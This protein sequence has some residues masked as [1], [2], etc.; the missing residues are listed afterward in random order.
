[1]SPKYHK[2]PAGE[3]CEECG[4][5][6]WY[7]QDALR[8]CRRGHLQ[9]GFAAHAADEEE[10]FAASQG[11]TTRQKKERPKKVAVK[12]SGDLGRELYLEVLQLVLRKQV[13]WLVKERGFPEELEEIVQGLWGLRVRS[14]P[15]KVAAGTRRGADSAGQDDDAMSVSSSAGG[16]GAGGLS[17][18]HDGSTAGG[19]G[20]SSSEWELSDTTTKSW[21]PDMGRRW[22]L[23][24]LIDSLALCYLGCL[25]RRLPVAAADLH[26]W[27]QEGKL[28]YL[29][30]VSRIL[31]KKKLEP[32]HADSD[33]K[34]TSLPKNVRDRLPAEFHRALQPGDHIKSGRLQDAIQDLVLAFKVNFDITFPPVNYVFTVIRYVR[35]LVL[36]CKLTK[37]TDHMRHGCELIQ[38]PQAISTLCVAPLPGS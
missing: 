30:S 31:F 20:E 4:S 1:M 17:S 12:L 3:R 15:L 19:G 14:L 11:R 6:Q 28:E 5:R 26:H 10:G 35:D 25:T 29:A 23:P 37:E 13:W 21:E 36:P 7:A 27:A 34:F 16:G 24:R 8:Y 22:K 33:G 38:L 2:F 18:Q 32:W 9:E